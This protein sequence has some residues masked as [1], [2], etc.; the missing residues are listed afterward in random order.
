MKDVK[1]HFKNLAQQWGALS[2]PLRPRSPV[3]ETLKALLPETAEKVL[4]LGVTP[5]YA[6]LAP[7]LTALDHSDV[8]VDQ[9]WP[10]DSDHRRA[11][12][13]RWADMPFADNSFD[14]VIGDGSLSMVYFP[15]GMDQ[16]LT[17][18]RRV[19]RKGGTAMFRIYTSPD[20]KPSD[21]EIISYCHSLKGHNVDA[22]RWRFVVHAVHDSPTPN[23][24]SG[25]AW[26]VFEA[27]FPD[28]LPLMAHNGWGQAEL[29]RFAL[30]KGGA[31]ALSVPTRAM[32]A[33][34]IGQHFGHVS[35]VS[36]GTYPMA[37][38]CPFA[39]CRD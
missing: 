13:G 26:R 34:I 19:L 28:P 17:E 15:S 16:V 27:M 2:L 4:M 36:S 22:L 29:D 32:T 12:I 31:M 35:F 8:M 38:L 9:V 20:E 33:Q 14:A 10:G 1:S 7:D 18:V 23:I 6:D 21:A 3:P 25:D 5:D 30:C 11:I 39:V 24:V 37:E